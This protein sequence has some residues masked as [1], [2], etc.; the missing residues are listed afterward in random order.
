MIVISSSTADPV[1]VFQLSEMEVRLKIE[2]KKTLVIQTYPMLSVCS[3]FCSSYTQEP[4]GAC[5]LSIL[6]KAKAGSW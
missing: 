4:L 6:V 1:L 5:L 3:D 2:N